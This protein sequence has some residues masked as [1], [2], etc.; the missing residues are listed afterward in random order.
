MSANASTGVLDPCILR[1]SVRKVSGTCV[2]IGTTESA[3]SE[4]L[5]VYHCFSLTEPMEQ[6]LGYVVLRH[7]CSEGMFSGMRAVKSIYYF[8][9]TRFYPIQNYVCGERK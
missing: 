3:Q 5:L 8:P 1:V 9:Q 7:R 6:N 4:I 2:R